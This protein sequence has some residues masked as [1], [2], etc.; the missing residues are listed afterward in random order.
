MFFA[1]HLMDRHSPEK[2]SPLTFLEYLKVTYPTQIKFID[3]VYD[4]QYKC[5]L[6]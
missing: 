3:Y 2:F 5:I 1:F 4:N 6:R